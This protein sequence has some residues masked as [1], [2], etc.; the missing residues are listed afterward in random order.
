MNYQEIKNEQAPL[1][2]CFFAFSKEQFEKG[3]AE[4]NL[5]GKKIYSGFGGLYGTEKGIK[6]LLHFYSDVNDR[7]AKECSPQE[8]Y[9]YEYDN[10]ECSI[11][12]DDSEAI[13]IALGIF[14]EAECKTIKRKN[15]YL[16]MSIDD[17]IDSM[18]KEMA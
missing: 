1:N 9:D 6:D 17:L 12:C 7:I 15:G 2:E 5:E 16:N 10:H 3:I 11:T 13:M 4:N 14:T 8:V 18:K